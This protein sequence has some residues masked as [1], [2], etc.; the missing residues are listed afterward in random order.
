MK[1][2]DRQAFR[3]VDGA[4][5]F[6][7][8]RDLTSVVL[9]EEFRLLITDIP[10]ALN[11]DCFSFEPGGQTEFFQILGILKSLADSVLDSSAR[12]FTPAVDSTLLDGFA[13][14]AREIVD[15]P[16]EERVV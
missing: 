11:N 12:R 13:C 15:T 1:L 3:V 10:E 14:D 9:R 2:F 6:G 7:D 8:A 16:R 4:V 5:P